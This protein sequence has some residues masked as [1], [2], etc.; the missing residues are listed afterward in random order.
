M[1]LHARR[2]DTGAA[3]EVK[4][5]NGVIESIKETEASAKLPWIAPGLVDLQ[6]N[7]YGGQE[8]NDPSLDVE[9]VRK[10]SLAMDADGVTKYCPTATTHSREVLLHTLEMLGRSCDESEDVAQRFAGI[11]LEGPYISRED[12]PRGAHPRQHCRPPDWEEFQQFQEAAGGRIRILTMSPEY[13]GSPGF[14]EKAARSGVLIAIGHTAADHEQI[15]AAVD[16]GARMSTHLGNGAHGEMRRHPNYIWDQL[17]NDGLTASLIV[18]GHHLPKEVVKCFV[19]AKSAA[20]CVL[21]SDLVGMAGMPPGR[22]HSTSNGNIEILE[23]GR[24]VVAGQ[25]Q[26][27]AGAGLPMTYGVANLMDFADVDLRTAVEMATRQPAS[28][29]GLEPVDLETNAIADLMLFELPT[30]PAQPIQV[31][32]TINGGEFTYRRED[33]R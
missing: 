2:F 32:T 17:A 24:L 23:D 22:Y 8:F 33:D 30:A 11:H 12:G 18:D 20:R 25:R 27:L 13:D 3:V 1:Q 31:V 10:V 29:I 19:R 9:K 15:E 6:V 7:G 14:I 26:Y 4:I 5:A 16:A 28:L 21:V